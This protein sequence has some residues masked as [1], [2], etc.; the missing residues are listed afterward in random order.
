MSGCTIIAR[1]RLLHHAAACLLLALL[2]TPSAFAQ[3]APPSTLTPEAQ[4]S[5]KKGILAAQQQDY[6]LAIQ[7]FQD[8]RK[9]AAGVYSPEVLYD[10]GLAESKI[11]GRE[12]RAI[13][14]FA[15][16]LAAAPG[17]PNAAA[18]QQQIDVLDVKSKSNLARLVKSVQDA[19]EKIP[20]RPSNLV[21]SDGGWVAEINRDRNFTDVA[22]L[23]ARAGNVSEAM[24]IGASLTDRDKLWLATRLTGP[25]L[26]LF[27][28]AKSLLAGIKCD[29]ATDPDVEIAGAAFDAASWGDAGDA[30]EILQ[31]CVANN[32]DTARTWVEVASTQFKQGD[33]DGARASLTL[34]LN[35]THRFNFGSVILAF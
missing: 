8:A 10:L 29:A 33:T 17:A 23:W 5:V 1:A 15:A 26:K 31:P 32:W 20:N 27:K 12:L 3:Q 7:Y 13:C 2:L 6:L 14:W 28:E 35:S 18:V 30:R 21:L 19:A 24:H 34:A 22:E 25:G 11:P 4:E 9:T 16:Y